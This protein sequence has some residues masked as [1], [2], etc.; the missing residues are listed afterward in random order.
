[1]RVPRPWKFGAAAALMAL[2]LVMSAVLGAAAVQR[3]VLRAPQFAVVLGPAR[4]AGFTTTTPNCRN[5]PG[6]GLNNS[7]CSTW[8]IT[9]HDEYY[10][11]WLTVRSRRGTVLYERANRLFV[12]RIGERAPAGN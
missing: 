6:L 10:T 8:S 2:A 12:L 11:V 4:F 1:M 7:F 9:S 5:P 3:R